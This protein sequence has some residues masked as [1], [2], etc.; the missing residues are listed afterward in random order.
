MCPERHLEGAELLGADVTNAKK[1][2]AGPITA[3]VVRKFMDD[4]S[5]IAPKLLN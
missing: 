1:A 2:D 4:V 3:D 5:I